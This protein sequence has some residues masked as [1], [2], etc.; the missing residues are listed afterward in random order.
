MKTAIDYQ[1]ESLEI[2]IRVL[3]QSIAKAKNARRNA[4]DVATLA[5]LQKQLEELKAKQHELEPGAMEAQD[6]T[7]GEA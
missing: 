5:G 4:A 3:S 7:D 2:Q 6:S 1:I